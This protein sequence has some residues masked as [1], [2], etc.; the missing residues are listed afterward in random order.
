MLPH[1]QTTGGKT[2]STIDEK[3]FIVE[4]N[5]LLKNCPVIQ[6]K[7][8]KNSFVFTN[9]KLYPYADVQQQIL[10]RCNIVSFYLFSSHKLFIP[11]LFSYVCGIVIHSQLQ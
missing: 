8:G 7:S 2:K 5:F 4:V 6:T 9:R 11:G 1:P 10:R 3:Q